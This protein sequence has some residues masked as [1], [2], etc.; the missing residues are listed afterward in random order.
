VRIPLYY[1]GHAYRKNSRI[2]VTISAPGGDQPVWAFGEAKPDSTPWVAIAHRR[3]NASRLVLPV[4]TG[5][6]APTALP[7]CPALR[8]EPCRDYVPLG[9]RRFTHG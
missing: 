2:R 8:G 9:N 1:E 6:G 3:H 7:Q 4:V 5:M